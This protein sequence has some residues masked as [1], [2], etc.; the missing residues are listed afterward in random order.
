MN[1]TVLKTMTTL[2]A[3]LVVAIALGGSFARCGLKGQTITT[4]EATKSKNSSDVGRSGRLFVTEMSGN[5]IH[6]MSP[7]VSDRASLPQFP[8]QQVC[9]GV[10]C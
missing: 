5:R 9:F 3:T 1:T 8:M 6:S 10:V 7:D 2:A 4:L